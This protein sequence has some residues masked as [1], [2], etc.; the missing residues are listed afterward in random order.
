MCGTRNHNQIAIWNG[1]FAGFAL[2]Q[3]AISAKRMCQ[4][5]ADECITNGTLG[6]VGIKVADAIKTKQARNN[7]MAPNLVPAA[8][9]S[10]VVVGSVTGKPVRVFDI[11]TET[12]PPVSA[13]IEHLHHHLQPAPSVSD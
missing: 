7:P 3:Q 1:R 6:Q 8:H 4:L 9:P 2:K 13:E 10:R 5:G 12:S 11:T